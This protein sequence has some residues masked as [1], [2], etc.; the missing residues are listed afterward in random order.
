MSSSWNF[1]VERKFLTTEEVLSSNSI[2]S[3]IT[4]QTS[5]FLISQNY[6]TSIYEEANS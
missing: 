6:G 3:V 4:K 1:E 2:K 5:E